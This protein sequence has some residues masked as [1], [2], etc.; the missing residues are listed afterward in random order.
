MLGKLLKHEWKATARLLLL[1]YLAV[2][3]FWSAPG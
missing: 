3:A 2:P 1:L